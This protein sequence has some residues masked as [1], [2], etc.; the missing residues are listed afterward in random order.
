[1][2]ITSSVYSIYL[3]LFFRGILYIIS[4]GVKLDLMA[5][6]Q[7]AGRPFSF[8]PPELSSSNDKMA[9]ATLRS[10]AAAATS[11]AKANLENED[12]GMK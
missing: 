8:K 11:L 1:M 5:R 7:G 9:M 12:L 10:W 3:S 2:C 4:T 6:R